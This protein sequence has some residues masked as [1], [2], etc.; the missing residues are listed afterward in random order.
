MLFEAYAASAHPAYP[1]RRN[2]KHQG[3]R[4][5]VAGH[6]CARPHCGKGADRQAWE[7]CR[8][9]AEAC[10]SLHTGSGQPLRL[11]AVSSQDRWQRHPRTSRKQVI[12][13]ADTRTDEDVVANLDAV[14]HHRLVFHSDPIANARARFDEGMVADIAI[15]PD[16]GSLHDVRESPYAS[17][18]ADLLAFAQRLGMNEDIG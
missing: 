14:P 2:T 18:P 12:R 6:D 15:A 1:P 10:A 13:K 8:L 16:H 17:T 7:D 3:I 5:N 11:L 4:E 9:C